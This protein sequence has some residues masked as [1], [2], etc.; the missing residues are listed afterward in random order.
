MDKRKLLIADSTEDFG[1]ALESALR[2]EFSIR[3]AAD[4]KEALRILDDFVPDVLVVDVMLPRRDGIGVLQYA[5]QHGHK[6]KVLVTTSVR[7]DYIFAKLMEL[8]VSY[9]LLKPCC[10]EIAAERVREIVQ[11]DT[12]IPAGHTHQRIA[13]IL[14]ELGLNPKHNGYHYLCKAIEEYAADSNQSLTKEL[15]A[16]VGDACDA[17]WQ[18]VERSIRAAIES[19]WKH[20]DERIWRKWFPAGAISALKRPTNG[21]VI[22]SLAQQLLLEKVEKIG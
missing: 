1:F 7:S 15:Y 9:L 3:I 21:A 13:E 8:E 19:A 22:C 17:G 4:G 2:D 18:Q 14:L 5:A 12:Q 16:A 20:R 10:L 11:T 6:P